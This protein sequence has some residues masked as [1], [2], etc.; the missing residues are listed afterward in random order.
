MMRSPFSTI[1]AAIVFLFSLSVVCAQPQPAAPGKMQAAP[2]TPTGP[3]TGRTYEQVPA[4]IDLRTTFSDGVYD[5]EGLV[6]TAARKGFKV[7]IFNDHDRVVMEYGLPPFRNIVKKKI[8]LNSIHKRGAESYLEAIREAGKRHPDMILIPGAESTPFYYWTGSPFSGTLTAKDHERRILAIGLDKPGD[9]E[10]LPVLHNG[11]SEG[12]LRNAWPA[13]AAF[14]ICFLI[15]LTFVLRHGWWRISGAVLA[16]LSA[17]F[18]VNVLFARPSP[19]DPYQG[20]QGAAPYQ[21]FIDDVGRKG[22][23]TF[24]NYPETRSGVRRLGPIHVS[25]KPYPEM[26]LETKDYTGFAALYGDTATVTE[27]GNVW[28]EALREYCAG[29]RK[30]PP[31]GIATSDFHKEGGAGEQLGNFQT[32]LWLTERSAHAVLEA[33]RSGR[34]YA[35]RGRFPRVP[36]LDEFSVSADRPDVAPRTISGQEVTLSGRPRIRIAVSA[37]S[38]GAGKEARLR[39]IRSGTVI[40]TARGLLPL[41]VDFTDIDAPPGKKIY[42]RMDLTGDGA[43][44]SNPIFVRL[45]NSSVDP[46]PPGSGRGKHGQAPK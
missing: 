41:Q 1:F 31:W 26:L 30:H 40:H 7:V 44:V 43:I 8:E 19:Y 18:F 3:M 24:W 35:A 2:P 17:A 15:A 21:L 16:L 45:A 33:L 27:P 29:Y 38:P 4:L 13:L 20:K 12:H 36:R 22:G 32:V 6:Q 37:G 9:Y 46:A 10:T 11:L 5:P 23:L 25:T 14:G 28:D 42:Y 39:L 34:M